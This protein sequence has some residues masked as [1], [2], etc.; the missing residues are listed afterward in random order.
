M[1]LLKFKCK[2]PVPMKFRIPMVVLTIAMYAGMNRLCAQTYNYAE[3][4]QKSMWFY[5]AQH[6][7]DIS[8]IIALSGAV[9]PALK[10]GSDAGM[11]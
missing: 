5:E 2:R 8:E 6:S 7:G 9:L 3:V 11:I 4:L 10:D 1:R